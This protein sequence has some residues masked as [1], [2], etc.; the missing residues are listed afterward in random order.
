MEKTEIGLTRNH[1]KESVEQIGM[2]LLVKEREQRGGGEKCTGDER[3]METTKRCEPSMTNVRRR[4]QH[5]TLQRPSKHRLDYQ[6]T[7]I[8]RADQMYLQCTSFGSSGKEEDKAENEVHTRTNEGKHKEKAENNKTYIK[9][10]SR[11]C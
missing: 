3:G 1:N 4:I 6:T 11:K 8:A 2:S 10:K 7:V 9:R 5:F